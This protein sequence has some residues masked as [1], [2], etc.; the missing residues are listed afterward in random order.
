MIRGDCCCSWTQGE[1]HGSSNLPQSY[2]CAHC[3]IVFHKRLWPERPDLTR[4][5]LEVATTGDREAFLLLLVYKS[6]FSDHTPGSVQEHTDAKHDFAFSMMYG[7]KFGSL[8]IEIG[9]WRMHK[10][11]NRICKRA[12]ERT[13]RE[14]Y[15]MVYNA[16][17]KGV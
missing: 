2:E 12:C 1:A 3:F 4:P 10:S 14:V 5:R 17:Y 7:P 6:T 15:G 8:Q 13:C 16:V 11:C 9:R